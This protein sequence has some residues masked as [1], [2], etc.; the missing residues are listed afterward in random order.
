V[1]RPTKLTPEVREQIA[2]SI[3]AGAYA[4]QAARAA[5]ISPSTFYD[6]LRRGEAGEAPFSEF[7]ETV[8]AREAEAEVAAVTMIRQ[9]A[10]AGDWRAAAHYLDRKHPERWGRLSP[11]AVERVE[12]GHPTPEQFDEEVE[13][14]LAAMEEE[15]DARADAR[16]RQRL[17]EDVPPEAV[18]DRARAAGPS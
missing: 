6:W 17:G 11:P 13:K 9:A 10:E 3:R 2:E 5:G 18:V 15:A 12:E 14:L 4:E 7:S 8:R 16:L 1:A